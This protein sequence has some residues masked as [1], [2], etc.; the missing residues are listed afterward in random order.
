MYA[1]NQYGSVNG[2]AMATVELIVISNKRLGEESLSSIEAELGLQERR[3]NSEALC[4]AAKTDVLM[5]ILAYRTM[6]E[7][8]QMNMIAR[9]N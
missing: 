7:E 9:S 5:T 6:G 1:T 3:I 4:M 2:K 8:A